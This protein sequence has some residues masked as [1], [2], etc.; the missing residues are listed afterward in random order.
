ML[1]FY[2]IL[3][4]SLQLN[5]VAWVA[6]YGA[7]WCLVSWITSVGCS[8][9]SSIGIVWFGPPISAAMNADQQN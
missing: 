7:G 9:P 5:Q 1:S 3:K 4:D 2:R 6:T 8:Q